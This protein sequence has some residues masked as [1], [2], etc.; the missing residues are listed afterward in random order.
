MVLKLPVPQTILTR[1]SFWL[2]QF[3]NLILMSALVLVVVQKTHM[4]RLVISF[5]Q[6]KKKAS[7]WLATVAGIKLY[8]WRKR[9][10]SG[11]ALTWL[12]FTSQLLPFLLCC[13]L[14]TA[15]SAPFKERWQQRREEEG[16]EM[17]KKGG[18]IMRAC[19]VCYCVNIQTRI[20]LYVCVHAHHHLV[21]T[22]HP[23]VS[24]HVVTF[25]VSIRIVGLI[26]VGSAHQCPGC[27]CVMDPS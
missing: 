10:R 23:H 19:G 22:T 11:A 24:L 5:G 3:S 27:L 17:A 16:A 12:A 2:W 14:E 20:H 9:S 4:T 15:P 18:I 6:I 1:F 7:D 8:T 26:L 21:C 13:D 25:S